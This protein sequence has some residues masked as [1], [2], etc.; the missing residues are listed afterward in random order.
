MAGSA[1]NPRGRPASAAPKPTTCGAGGDSIA[2]DGG[3][4]RVY[5]I[6]ET[7]LFREGLQAILSRDGG[8]NVVGHGSHADAPEEIGRLA[9]QSALLDMAGPE[10]LAIPRQLHL[11]LPSL[12]IVAVAL[13][14]QDADVIACAEAGISAYVPQGAA[15]EDLVA[16]IRR[17]LVGE[18]ICSPRIT[19]LLF[20]RVAVLTK[21]GAVPLMDEVLTPRERQIAGLMARG[22]PNKEI[23]R[24]LFLGNAT[25]KNHVH[26]I[27]QKLKVQR[28]GEIFGRR[29]DVEVRV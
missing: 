8:L 11:I 5:I 29:F 25:V 21:A 1:P 24:R 20:E 10:S 27:L 15:A 28:R 19:A 16:A 3:P 2:L 12:R 9:P 17:S 6:S 26:N 7:R 14:D 22:L 18:L 4:P 23:A 13:S